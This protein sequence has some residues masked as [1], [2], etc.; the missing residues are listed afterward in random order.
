MLKAGRFFPD[1]LRLSAQAGD[2]EGGQDRPFQQSF[3]FRRIWRQAIIVTSL[4][5]L[6]PLVVIT[7]VNYKLTRKS[8]EEEDILRTLRVGS[9]AK[10]SVSFFLS[11][12][13]SALT[14]IA[15]DNS[16]DSLK[17]PERLRGILETLDASFNGFVDLGLIDQHGEQL[18]YVG[19]YA[20]Q[21]KQYG[22]QPWFAEIQRQGF[23]V[24]EMILGYRHQPHMVLAARQKM[25]DGGFFVLRA[26]IDSTRFIET[27]K[28]FE[29]MGRG[30][31]FLVNR[32]GK[33][34]TRSHYEGRLFS[35]VPYA[36]EW[37]SEETAIH[38]DVT[39]TGEPVIVCAAKIPDS[40]FILMIVKRGNDLIRFWRNTGLVLMAFVGLSIIVILFVIFSVCTHMVNSMYQLDLRQRA[41]M[42]DVEQYNK[43]ASIG[44]LAAG[45]AHEVNNPLAIINEKA[46]LIKDIFSFTDTYA[47]DEKII[48]L[49]DSVLASV[50]RCGAI[51]KRLLS[52]ARHMDSVFE[53]VRLPVVIDEV[54]GF[55]K[56]E[57]EY[58]GINVTVKFA[59][60]V[61]PFRSDRGKLQQV[62]LNL[63]NNAFAAMDKGGDLVVDV[64][65]DGPATIRACVIDSGSGIARENLDKIFE[66]FFST[67]TKT[68]GTGLGLSITYGLVKELGGDI[69][70]DSAMGVGTVFAVTLPLE[71]P[72]KSV[73]KSDGNSAR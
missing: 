2:Q 53:E 25:A 51:T 57:A 73:E 42:R 37:S 70:V 13:L 55:L 69:Q 61:P 11:E 40:P 29:L 63:I 45:V 64:K 4:V 1:F 6:V 38:H 50:E 5:A 49:I 36:I 19:P 43:L 7:L 56:K 27:L 8:I 17:N 34:Q 72:Q 30:D 60:E 26:T 9:N 10:H 21:A 24:S 67:K 47:K 54:L 46:G 3:D 22:D 12:R 41:T 31:L 39:A 23:L 59:N 66:P 62:F 65:M 58:R 18:N 20:L 14:F 44:R 52:F 16:F 28:S 35:K 33:L 68:G 71:P 48:G 32:E 15:M